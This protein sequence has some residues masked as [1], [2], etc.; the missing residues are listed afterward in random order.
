MKH[1]RHT[2]CSQK[3]DSNSSKLIE[4]SRTS[5]L[6]LIRQ[7][8][9]VSQGSKHIKKTEIISRDKLMTYKAVKQKKTLRVTKSQVKISI[10]RNRSCEGKRATQMRCRQHSS[11]MII[12]SIYKTEKGQRLQQALEAK[13]SVKVT[14]GSFRQ[15]THHQELI[16]N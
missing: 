15:R 7:S 9:N 2:F 1:L 5:S 14:G 10:Q 8:S 13:N 12:P 11:K 4:D 6:K 3:R 16:N